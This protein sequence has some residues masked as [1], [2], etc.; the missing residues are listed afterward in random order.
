MLAS[1]LSEGDAPLPLA[2]AEPALP[3]SLLRSWGTSHPAMLGGEYLPERRATEMEIAR[4]TLQSVTQDVICLYAAQGRG[5]IRY[6][7]VDE[8][9]GDTLSGRAGRTSSQPLTLGGLAE[10]FLGAWNPEPVL[11]VNFSLPE[12]SLDEALEFMRGESAF[13]LAFDDLLRLRIRS[14]WAQRPDG[15]G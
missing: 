14:W 9:G 5:R 12:S 1:I 4:I 8:Y 15:A 10:F 11:G 7:V 2:L 6:R 3:A 13:Y